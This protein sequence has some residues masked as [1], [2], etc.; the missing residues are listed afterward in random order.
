MSLLPT[1]PFHGTVPL[2]HPVQPKLLKADHYYRLRV[3][4][5]EAHSTP[6]APVPDKEIERALWYCFKTPGRPKDLAPYVAATW[7]G[8][9]DH[10]FL[11][12]SLLVIFN[13]AGMQ[14]VFGA[15]PRMNVLDEDGLVVATNWRAPGPVDTPLLGQ[16]LR[17]VPSRDCQPAPTGG[18]AC[19][20]LQARRRYTI[21][22]TDPTVSGAMTAPS[23]VYSTTFTTSRFASFAELI[24]RGPSALGGP[25]VAEVDGA[26]DLQLT[27][28]VDPRVPVTVPGGQCLVLRT[29]EPLPWAEP[30]RMFV[31]LLRDAAGV[32]F[33]H[34]SPDGSETHVLVPVSGSGGGSFEPGDYT[35]RFTYTWGVLAAN[36]P[37]LDYADLG[38]LVDTGLYPIH[39]EQVSIRFK[40][41]AP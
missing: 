6:A 26:M 29:A 38:L 7:P 32:P 18:D 39:P 21:E 5:G 41:V 31:E 1:D 24:E 16:V 37:S 10:A 9:T 33:N 15:P 8:A 14:A 40:M 22:L 3:S 19:P 17:V 2:G 11:D 34:I 28:C 30:G 35:L 25:G 13:T 36:I 20:G 12:E 23:P 4:L 27:T